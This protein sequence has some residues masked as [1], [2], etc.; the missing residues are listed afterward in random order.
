MAHFIAN[1]QYSNVAG[2]R[3]ITRQRRGTGPTIDVTTPPSP[4]PIFV[5][6][7]AMK[8]PATLI[9]ENEDDDVN[10]DDDVVDDVD[11]DDDDDDDD[12]AEEE[13]EEEEEAWESAAIRSEADTYCSKCSNSSSSS[14]KSLC[15]ACGRRS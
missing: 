6:T 11:D 5:N 4:S 8:M 9:T 2:R 14:G 12:D 15:S 13:E 7:T 3:Q 1:F 10:V